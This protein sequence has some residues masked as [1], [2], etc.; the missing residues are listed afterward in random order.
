[1]KIKN[2]VLT[3]LF[4]AL[5]FIF[6]AYFFHIPSGIGGG[7]IHFGDAFIF[8]AATLLPFPAA[9]FVGA[10]GAGFA[11]IFTGAGIWAP[12]TLIIKPLMAL[13][14]T[15]KGDKILK[16]KRNRMAPFLAGVI[17]IVGYYLAE[18]FLFGNFS[19]PLLS[20]PGSFVQ[21]LLSIVCYYVFA[22]V[23]DTRDLKTKLLL[24]HR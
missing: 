3:G 20:L 9:I 10:I 21:F 5:V 14:F 19:A 6:T 23:I 11:D 1:M 12:F 2:L 7:Y 24:S 22:R 18:G 13:C 8:L 16:N 4:S 15:N 17:C